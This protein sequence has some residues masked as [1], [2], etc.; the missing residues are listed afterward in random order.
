[1]T[2]TLLRLLPT[3]EQTILHC[4][5]NGSNE[6]DGID[7][8]YDELEIPDD[9]QAPRLAIAVAQIL[10]H[11]I[12]DT[13]PQWASGSGDTLSLNRDEHKRHKEARLE[14]N[15]KLVCTINWADSGPGFSWPEAYHITYLPGFNKFVVT[16]SRDGDDMWGCADHAIGVADGNLEP[17]EAAKKAITAYWAGQVEDWDQ[18]RWAYLFDEGLVD[19]NTAN[20]WADAVWTATDDDTSE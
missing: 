16:A 13:L 10:L 7:A 12:Q 8:I 9:A 5:L 3:A 11:H 20:A 19:E 17:V 2:A 15:P 18:N 6:P 14:F 1:M 4:Y